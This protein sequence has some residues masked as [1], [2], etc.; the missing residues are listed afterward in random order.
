VVHPFQSDLADLWKGQNVT[1]EE[2]K[3]LAARAAERL[4]AGR[5]A[6]NQ[7]RDRTRLFVRAMLSCAPKL[8]LPELIQLE[9]T[10][11]LM[12]ALGVTRSMLGDELK[13]ARIDLKAAAEVDAVRVPVRTRNRRPS[14]A[15]MQ[16]AAA[17]T[18]AGSAVQGRG[19]VANGSIADL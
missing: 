16:S 10:K 6:R 8:K 2:V 4:L 7:P 5:E 14:K 13:A 9:E 11:Q 1:E 18:A 15:D 3:T 12:D 17:P 19:M